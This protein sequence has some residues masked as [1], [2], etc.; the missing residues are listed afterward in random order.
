MKYIFFNIWIRRARICCASSN[1]NTRRKQTFNIHTGSVSEIVLFMVQF[2]EK[3]KNNIL[4]SMPCEYSKLV[5]QGA[6]LEINPITLGWE[7]P[8]RLTK[9]LQN[10]NLSNFWQFLDVFSVCYD[11]IDFWFLYLFRHPET[12]LQYMVFV[13]RT[14][15]L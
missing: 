3:P 11:G 14:V 13:N 4:Q 2:Q 6:W 8:R 10:L 1:M 5:S 12:Y 9:N 15:L 7:N